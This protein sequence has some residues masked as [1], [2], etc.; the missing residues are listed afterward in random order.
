MIGNVRNIFLGQAA[1]FL[2]QA[3]GFLKGQLVQ[4]L[5]N[6]LNQPA[7]FFDLFAGNGKS[8]CHLCQM[9][10]I[11]GRSVQQLGDHTEEKSAHIPVKRLAASVQPRH[12]GN[13]HRLHIHFGVGRVQRNVT[14]GG[15]AADHSTAGNVIKGVALFGLYHADVVNMGV[16]GEHTL[17]SVVGKNLPGGL[18]IALH[19]P[20]ADNGIKRTGGEHGVMGHGDHKLIIFASVLQLIQDPG[21]TVVAVPGAALPLRLIVGIVIQGKQPIA[22][23]QLHHIAHAVRVGSNGL[24]GAELIVHLPQI[25][26]LLHRRHLNLFVA[27][28]AVGHTAVPIIVGSSDHIHPLAPLFQV[29]EHFNK[30]GVRGQFSV[31]GGI[32]GQHHNI[33]GSVRAQQIE[34]GFDHQVAVLND[35]LALGLGFF[36]SLALGAPLTGVVM[37]IGDK[38]NFQRRIACAIQLR[39]H[40]VLLYFISAFSTPL[41]TVPGRVISIQPSLRKA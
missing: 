32:A 22:G 8:V 12:I 10:N 24:V 11:R 1:F 30:L 25:V 20:L 33:R 3:P 36:V 34:P 37:R 19:I 41:R 39:C 31:P 15:R 4:P 9:V 17:Q 2:A 38:L 40:C 35:L 21:H 7:Q 16:A 26:A 14:H 18:M 13:G 29:P 6:G 5:G 28:I 23:G 27:V